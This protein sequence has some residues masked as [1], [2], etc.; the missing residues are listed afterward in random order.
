MLHYNRINVSEGIG[1]IKRSGSKERII[2]QYYYFLDKEFGFQPTVCNN[3]QDIF[4]M[5]IDI[6]NNEAI[7]LRKNMH[8]CKI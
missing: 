3:H 2:C 1:I 8:L 7:N 5:S 6:S 4:I